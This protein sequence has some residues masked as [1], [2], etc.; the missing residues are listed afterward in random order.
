MALST[1]DWKNNKVKCWLTSGENG[2]YWFS[3]SGSV[4]AQL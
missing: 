2:S 1:F 4:T 3:L